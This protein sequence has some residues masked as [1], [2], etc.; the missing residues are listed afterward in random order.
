MTQQISH[1]EPLWVRD[2]KL[3][4]LLLVPEAVESSEDI[5]KFNFHNYKYKWR[6]NRNLFLWVGEEKFYLMKDS[7]DKGISG[8]LKKLFPILLEELDGS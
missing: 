3:K 8:K 2:L 1:D 6:I 5:S 4:L 7:P